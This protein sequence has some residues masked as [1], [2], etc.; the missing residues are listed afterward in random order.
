MDSRGNARSNSLLSN[1][2]SAAAAQSSQLAECSSM[3]R[4]AP[5]LAISS[6]DSRNRLQ[7]SSFFFTKFHIVPPLRTATTTTAHPA[8]FRASVTI[9]LRARNNRTFTVFA[10]RSSISAISST[11][12]PSTSFKINI[13]LS[14]SSRHSSRSLYLL[15]RLQCV[16]DIWRWRRPF[17]RCAKLPR[18]IFAQIRFINERP[19]FPFPQQVPA[20]V[21]RD[22]VQ[23]RAERC[24]L[25]KSLQRKVSLHENL[26]RD[27]LDILALPQNSAGHRRPR[28]VGAGA[29]VPRTRPDLRP[30][31][32][33]RVPG[34]RPAPQ[35]RSCRRA[36]RTSGLMTAVAITFGTRPMLI[37]LRLLPIQLPRR[38]RSDLS[39]FS[40]ASTSPLHHVFHL[41]S[42]IKLYLRASYLHAIMPA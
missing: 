17:F 7:S 42:S 29:P 32:V 5:P 15:S 1:S 21:H 25:I 37:R 12:N 36:P 40:H 8:R 28:D 30:A 27:I 16:A 19:H 14:R 26:L 22:L 9:L 31:R 39:E 41:P 6:S 4:D 11:A 20:F 18:L 35:L 34:R 13:I 23:P 33:A 2:S 38:T 10:L 24:S 3:S